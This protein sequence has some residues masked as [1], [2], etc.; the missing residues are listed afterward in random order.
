[1]GLLDLFVSGN[2]AILGNLDSLMGMVKEG[3]QQKL[4][5]A[6][7]VAL[8]TAEDLCP[9]DTGFLRSRL[10]LVE[11]PGRVTVTN[12]CDYCIPVELGHHTRSGSF[13]PPQPFMV[14][15]MLAGAD[16]LKNS[17]PGLI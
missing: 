17:L 16:H 4:E 9:V 13:V 3:V 2:T 7:T 8:Q 6:G 11:E 14:P 12:D 1:M 15:G 10:D 5:E